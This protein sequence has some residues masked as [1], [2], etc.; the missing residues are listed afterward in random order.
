LAL[1]AAFEV[2]VAFG[3]NVETRHL[4]RR[5]AIA[6]P[7]LPLQSLALESPKTLRPCLL[8]LMEAL[9]G[10]V[11]A[12]RVN[13]RLLYL[14]AAGRSLLGVEPREPLAGLRMAEFYS[15]RAYD[16]LLD[17]V[18]PTCLQGGVWSGEITL[19]DRQR[20]EI[21]TSQI[22]IAHNV[23]QGASGAPVLASIAWDMRAYKSAE[24][25]LR[26]QATHDALTDSPN[27]ALLMD[28]LAQAIHR[29]ERRRRIVG[30]L[31]L[32]LNDF[33]KIN[34]TFGHES[35]NHVLREL[36]ERLRMRLRAE[37]TVARYGGD[38]FV[39]VTPDLTEATDIERVSRQ[40][41]EALD[42]PFLVNGTPIRAGASIGV[43]LYPIDG[44][45]A[46][47]LVRAAD[48]AM[49]R[50]KRAK[51]A[52]TSRPSS[53]PIPLRAVAADRGDCSTPGVGLDP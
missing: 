35:A 30:V 28:R 32:D 43:A 34:D 49:Y 46:E 13:G 40:A 45:D 21:P 17:Q 15:G 33:K 31:F 3:I 4:D 44:D 27:R 16:L 6:L 22:F 5:T 37:D 48:L 9:P 10:I 8:G 39:L 36:A 53:T 26:R 23:G 11:M 51:N 20:Q 42:E 38:E 41:R 47:T 12:S 50:V 25:I 14:N 7:K 24:R 1:L 29:A 52:T 18:I 19:R 2:D